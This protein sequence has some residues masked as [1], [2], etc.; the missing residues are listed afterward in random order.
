MASIYLYIPPKADAKNMHRVYF[1]LEH[2]RTNVYIKNSSKIPSELVQFTSNGYRF[3][4]KFLEQSLRSLELDLQKKLLQYGLTIESMTAKEIAERLTGKSFHDIFRLNFIEFLEKDYLPTAKSKAQTKVAINYLKK[5]VG[6]DYLEISEMTKVWLQ[7]YYAWLTTFYDLQDTFNK[8]VACLARAF[9]ACQEK[10]NNEDEGG[11]IRIPKNPFDVAVK[12]ELRK[13][14]K[15]AEQGINALRPEVMKEMLDLPTDDMPEWELMAKDVLTLSFYFCGLN[16]TDIYHNC[17][18][19]DIN[20]E[21]YIEYVRGKTSQTTPTKVRLKVEPFLQ[22]L[23]DKYKPYKGGC[24]AFNFS[25]HHL[26]Y[27][28]FRNA[29]GRGMAKLALRLI[30]KYA[31]EY[32]ITQLEASRILGLDNFTMYVARRTWASIAYNQ[33]KIPLD[34]IDRC[35]GHIAKSVSEIHYIRNDFSMLEFAK[36]K[37]I[38]YMQNME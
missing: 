18:R 17:D 5:Y 31:K 2:N 24:M 6:K 25:Q 11:Y 23:V 35:L 13:V 38:D 1:R 4:D 28:A 20:G 19:I 34:V 29:L 9:K 27:Q 22:D 26:N 3:K 16:L 10:Y 12:P 30:K 21:T 37:V 32:N 14:S 36:L 15:K 8:H 7:E 33:C